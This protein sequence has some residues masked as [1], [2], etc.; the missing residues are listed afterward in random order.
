ILFTDDDILPDRAL[1]QAHLA[2][3]ERHPR[4]AIGVL[5]NVR[6]ADELRVTPF[7]RWLE[8]G[9]QFN[10]PSIVGTEVTWGYFYTANASVKRA[11]LERVG[12]FDEQRLPYL[13]EDLDVA[14][15]MHRSEGL[16]LLYEPRARAEHLHAPDLDSWRRR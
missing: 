9:I 4:D 7:M 6:W 1:V 16:R 12:G 14:L 2:C 15:R 3:H 10:Y 5:G 8:H 13:Y 11:A